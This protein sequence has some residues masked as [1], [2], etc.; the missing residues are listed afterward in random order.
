MPATTKNDGTVKWTSVQTSGI[1]T[2]RSAQV[3]FPTQVPNPNPPP[4]TIPGTETHTYTVTEE[5]LAMLDRVRPNDRVE[6]TAD[7][8]TNPAT[9][10]GLKVVKGS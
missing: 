4:P 9:L 1:V 7:H 6:C 8:S 5:L 2:V 3:E 10:D